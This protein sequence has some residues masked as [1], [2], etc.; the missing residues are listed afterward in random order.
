MEFKN[1]KMNWYVIICYVENFKPTSIQKC[2]HD[3]MIESTDYE[4]SF[5]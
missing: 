5:T 3:K 4:K 1:L 2:S